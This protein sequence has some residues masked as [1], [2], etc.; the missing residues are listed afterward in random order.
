MRS[1]MPTTC[2]CRR[3]PRPR[4]ET[5]RRWS[6]S[7]GDSRL[8]SET[9]PSRVGALA[10]AV[11]VAVLPFGLG[12]VL[13]VVLPLRGE[14]VRHRAGLA[15]PVPEKFDLSER[16]GR[17][18]RL[19]GGIADVH[20]RDER[21]HRPVAPEGLVLGVKAVVEHL[22]RARLVHV[23]FHV[24]LHRAGA[25]GGRLRALR[26]EIRECLAMVGLVRDRRGQHLLVAVLEL[27]LLHQHVQVGPRGRGIGLHAGLETASRNLYG[28]C[29]TVR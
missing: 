7:C 14:R 1:C 22:R 4:R 6:Q 29:S 13:V 12:R 28:E 21:D 10:A 11:L 16:L 27:D 20:L 25:L 8:G 18:H 19:V 9:S 15:F 26:Y 24:H 2:A 3:P 23:A 17:E 5:C